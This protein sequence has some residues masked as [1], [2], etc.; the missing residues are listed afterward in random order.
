MSVCVC[1]CFWVLYVCTG[2]IHADM[3]TSNGVQYTS[4]CVW[5]VRF[6]MRTD[7]F[8]YLCEYLYVILVY[9]HDDS[10]DL[11]NIRAKR[12]SLWWP[13]LSLSSS[14]VCM[15]T[16]KMLMWCW[17]WWWWWS[18]SDDADDRMMRMVC[19]V[20]GTSFALWVSVSLSLSI[21]LRFCCVLLYYIAV[22]L[23]YK[24]TISTKHLNARHRA[25]FPAAAYLSLCMSIVCCAF[26]CGSEIH[27]L[28]QIMCKSQHTAAHTFGD[29]YLLVC[30]KYIG[31]QVHFCLWEWC[32]E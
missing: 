16:G 27:A 2:E 24:Y 18:S 29:H 26:H 20:Y 25:R 32:W 30:S 28:V 12:A 7:G 4:L 14:R 10:F 23:K 9:L 17:W 1:V 19:C 21:S 15:S 31:Q 13:L 3:F 11:Y 8:S 6:A 5:G 22:G